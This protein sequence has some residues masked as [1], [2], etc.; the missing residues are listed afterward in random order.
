MIAISEASACMSS[1]VMCDWS[2]HLTAHFDP[3]SRDTA[4][5][6]TPNEPVP[7]VC[8]ISYDA[9]GEPCVVRKEAEEDAE[10]SAM[11]EG[12]TVQMMLVLPYITGY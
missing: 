9:V 1:R 6:T 12:I 10:E 7:S 3:S 4:S 8:W 11:M 2:M 5:L